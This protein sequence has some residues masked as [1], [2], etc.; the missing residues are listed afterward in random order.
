VQGQPSTDWNEHWEIPALMQWQAAHKSTW[1]NPQ[2]C[3]AAFLPHLSMALDKQVVIP[4]W[5]D[6]DNALHT[7]QQT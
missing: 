2:E 4:H 7:Q 6:R 3:L 5:F 1:E